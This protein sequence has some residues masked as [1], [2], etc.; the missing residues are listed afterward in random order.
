MIILIMQHKVRARD[1]ARH[2]RGCPMRLVM[3]FHE[4][5]VCMCIYIYIYIRVYI[6]IYIY[7]TTTTTTTDDDDDD[8][9]DNDD[10]RLRQD[11]PG[12]RV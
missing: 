12:G 10:N 3:C 1:H 6:Y 7:I 11:V 4:G 5:Y 2:L 9:D 8:D